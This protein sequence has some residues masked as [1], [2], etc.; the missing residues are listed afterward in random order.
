MFFWHDPSAVRTGNVSCTNK[1]KATKRKTKT[2]NVR[3][4]LSET[5]DLN[6]N[7]V[8]FFSYVLLA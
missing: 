6:K 3:V 8:F 2:D 4:I 7:Q 5:K 1:V